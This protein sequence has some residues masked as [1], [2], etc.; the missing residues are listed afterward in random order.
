MFGFSIK[1]NAQE[2]ISFRSNALGGVIN[3]DLD[4]IYDPIELQFVDSLRLYTNLSNLTSGNE[5]LFDN[6]SDDEF[7]I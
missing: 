2:P 5:K 4:L 6:I 7:R 1:V 3:D